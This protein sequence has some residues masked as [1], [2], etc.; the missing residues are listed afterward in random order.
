MRQVNLKP[1]ICKN[2]SRSHVFGR[3]RIRCD[4][5]RGSSEEAGPGAEG[6]GQAA[7]TA[8]QRP[9]HWATPRSRVHAQM[10]GWKNE[11]KYYT[12]IVFEEKPSTCFAIRPMGTSCRERSKKPG[13]AYPSTAC[14][15]AGR[16]DSPG[17][18]ASAAREPEGLGTALVFTSNPSERAWLR[19]QEEETRR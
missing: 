7:Q 1:S 9:A 10:Q 2:G 17:D 19:K 11:V 14:S 18:K 15:G 8:A 13:R 16:L 5:L 4:A 3:E 12:E 6:C